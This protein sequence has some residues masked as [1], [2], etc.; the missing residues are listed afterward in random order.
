MHKAKGFTLVETLV[1]LALLGILM[2]MLQA[3]M[4]VM[5]DSSRKVD[6]YVTGNNDVSYILYS[7][8]KDLLNTNSVSISSNSMILH[9]SDSD[10]IYEIDASS[11]RR[12]SRQIA[13]LINGS[14]SYNDEIINIAITL[15]DRS[16]VS[17]QYPF[18]GVLDVS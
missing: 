18:G 9:T 2:L 13:V 3:V 5:A 6:D 4:S 15:A 8:K 14:F 16:I 1:A 11:L 17:V 10:I 7:I 12:N